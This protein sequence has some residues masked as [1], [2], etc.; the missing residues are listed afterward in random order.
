MSISDAGPGIREAP[1]LL[2]L[3]GPWLCTAGLG[4]DSKGLFALG[5][6]VA[7]VAL[8]VGVTH[9]RHEPDKALMMAGLLLAIL[10]LSTT[11][12]WPSA[13]TDA[14]S[15]GETGSSTSYAAAASVLLVALWAVLCVHITKTPNMPPSGGR[16]SSVERWPQ[17]AV[18][19]SGSLLVATSTLFMAFASHSSTS[20]LASGIPLATW[21]LGWVYLLVGASWDDSR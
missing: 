10:A 11:V 2:G 20:G 1:L 13:L 17:L 5:W 6:I 3:W 18:V 4:K 21:T 15:R 9:P 16:A 19:G 12:L 8:I 14:S 7:S